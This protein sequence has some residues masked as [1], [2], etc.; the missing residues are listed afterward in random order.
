MSKTYEYA[1]GLSIG[2]KFFKISASLKGSTTVNSFSIR[3]G[4]TLAL[5][6]AYDVGGMGSTA[7]DTVCRAVDGEKFPARVL[8]KKPCLI[9]DQTVPSTG[10]K[11]DFKTCPLFSAE[12]Q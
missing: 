9:L 11:P 8:Y 3:D 2:V 5:T 7:V 1:L 12:I 10:H 6:V 4:N